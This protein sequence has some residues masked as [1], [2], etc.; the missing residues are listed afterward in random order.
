MKKLIAIAAPSGAGKTSIVNHLLSSI[1]SLRF[2]ISATT[3]APRGKEIHGKEYYFLSPEEFK[4]KIKSDAFIEWEE[5]YPDQYYGSL[6]SEV[7]RVTNEGH[8]VI[9]DID[10]KGALNIKKIYPE[11]L[12]I[13]I[14]PPSLD[15][16]ARRLRGRNTEEESSLQK[17]I[18]KAEEEL[19]FS[20]SFDISLINDDFDKACVEAANIVKE[21][22]AK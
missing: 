17:R 5:V 6:K 22:L 16:L 4:A 20:P 8:V 1:P 21:Y 10:V 9:F 11:T 2:S 7:D 14:L 12:T 15:E 19:S 18:G 3:R 13:F